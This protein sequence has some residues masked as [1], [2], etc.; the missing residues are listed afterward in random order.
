VVYAVLVETGLT[1][2]TLGKIIMASTF[3][4]DFGTALALSLLFIHPTWWLVPFLLV[5]AAIIL[6]MPRLQPWFFPR[7]GGRV[8]EP[9]IK[10][11]FAALLIMMWRPSSRPPGTGSMT[12][13]WWAS[14][15]TRMSS[16]GSWAAP[17]RISAVCRLALC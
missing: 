17:R 6:I 16:A 7:Y 9:E 2:T 11:A 10:G 12:S 5:S 3:V 13:W 1:H 14:W 4:T 8:I 15:G